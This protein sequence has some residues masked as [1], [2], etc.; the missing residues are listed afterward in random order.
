M[1]D[2]RGP[3]AGIR[4]VEVAGLGPV[5]FC[6]MML[7][8]MGAEVVLVERPGASTGGGLRTA[9][10]RNRRRIVLDL[11]SE[12]GL[13]VLLA[14]NWAIALICGAI[15]LIAAFTLRIS[16]ASSLAA[17]AA[18]PVVAAILQVPFPLLIATTLVAAL[19][20]QRHQPNIARLAAGTE[21]RIGQK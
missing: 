7:G 17:S 13:G 1:Q 3:L 6:G 9:L 2:R 8:D 18:A 19:I 20:W 14:A 5:P 21:P 4:V 15:W 16:S 12:A 10:E 11:K